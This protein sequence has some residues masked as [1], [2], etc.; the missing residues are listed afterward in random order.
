MKRFLTGYRTEQRTLKEDP[1]TPIRFTITTEGVK[2][3]GKNLLIAG[4]RLE[5]FKKN[6][7]V[8]WCHDFLGKRLPIGRADLIV[9]YQKLEADFFF[10]QLDPFARDIESKY[11]RGFLN[12]VSVSWDSIKEEGQNVTEWELFEVACVPVGGDPLALVQRQMEGLGSWLVDNKQDL[13]DFNK[14][15]LD[16]T[17]LRLDF[18][19]LIK[20]IREEHR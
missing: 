9:G 8:T 7:C 1:G 18:Q 5:N 11:R 4:A 17:I 12:A 2:R 20:I 6:P 19:K 14:L 10:D 16:L 3:D 13:P 15:S